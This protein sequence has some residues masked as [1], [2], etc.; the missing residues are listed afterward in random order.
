L[1]TNDPFDGDP[2][3][4]AAY[5]RGDPAVVVPIVKNL[6]PSVLGFFRKKLGRGMIGI[7]GVEDLVQ[8]TMMKVFGAAAR[9][10][11]D[12]AKGSLWSYA[13]RTAVNVWNDACRAKGREPGP[14]PPIEMDLVPDEP[15]TEEELL[16]LRREAAMEEYFDTLP[17][18]ERELVRLVY[19]EG[20]PLTAAAKR[21]G[22]SRGVARALDREI[23]RGLEAFLQRRGLG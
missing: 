14:E 23:K 1:S 6:T 10:N 16:R 21:M 9:K 7:S 4:L 12:P 17:P 18:L 20:N 3:L 8:K 22:L 5:R 15:I 2:D 11:W 19:E 13:N